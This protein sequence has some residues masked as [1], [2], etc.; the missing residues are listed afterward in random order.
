LIATIAANPGD[1]AGALRAA[2]AVAEVDDFF[3]DSIPMALARAPIVAANVEEMVMA[4]RVLDRKRNRLMALWLVAQPLIFGR[5]GEALEVVV[6]EA[7]LV[8]GSDQSLDVGIELFAAWVQADADDP[9]GARAILEAALPRATDEWVFAALAQ[10][11]IGETAAALSTAKRIVDAGDRALVLA[12]VAAG[13]RS[14]AWL[15]VGLR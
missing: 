12:W 4:S 15:V 8:A 9:A 1:R 10:A 13:G 3:W 11:R 6:R 14:L 5:R 2:V 7:V